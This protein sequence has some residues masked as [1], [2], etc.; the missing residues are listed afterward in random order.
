MANHVTDPW[1][2]AEIEQ[3]A[4]LKRER[5]SN[6]EI[7]RRLGRTRDAV[8]QKW[9][10]LGDARERIQPALSAAPGQDAADEL[11]LARESAAPA[12]AT[13]TP[14]WREDVD[15][16]ELWQRV[17]EEN[18]R[19]IA[20]ALDSHK[21]TATFDR[22]DPI[23]IAAK[24]DQHIAPGTPVDMARMRSDAEYVR[25]TPNLFST[26]AGDG[27]D[28]HIKHRSATI[29]ARSQPGD[30]WKH[31][32]YLML[33][34]REK[35]LALICGNHDAWT[36]QFAGVDMVK[37]LAEKNALCYAPD[38]ARLTVK[39]G[40]QEYKIAFRHQYRMNSTFNQTHAVK[41]W[42]RL[43]DD[44]FDVGIIGHH[45]EPAIESFVY[46]G[47]ECWAARPGSYQIT[48]AYSRMY[49]YNSTYPTCPTF[50]LFPDK[51]KIV[52]FSDMR[53]AGVYLKAVL[54]K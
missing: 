15:P 34:E 11:R 41:Q 43:G 52:G 32:D 19:H 40:S 36:D 24:S 26:W 22:N 30:Q 8:G 38:E 27:V 13:V 53:D 37:W 10:R 51:R 29:A 2:E 35:L 9:Q 1:T 33:I 17:E 45:H 50:V 31:Y 18:A 4:A 42:Q 47:K 23:A 39:V 5:L 25:D 20:K 16:G 54:G 49:G 6:A 48:S 21:F 12:R 46:R 44:A 7:G 3:L 14:F 28:N